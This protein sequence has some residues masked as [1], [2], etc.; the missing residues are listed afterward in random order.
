MMFVGNRLLSISCQRKPKLPIYD[1]VRSINNPITGKFVIANGFSLWGMSRNPA[2]IRNVITKV[3]TVPSKLS[4]DL[5][6]FGTVGL[7]PG[8]GVPAMG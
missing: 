7:L 8:P 1:M 4:D 2:E 6:E 5:Y 3:T